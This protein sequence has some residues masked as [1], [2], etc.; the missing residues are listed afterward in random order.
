MSSSI[1]GC[2][3]N[4]SLINQN[5]VE[6][7]IVLFPVPIQQYLSHS[8]NNFGVMKYINS[9][10]NFMASTCIYRTA[11][12]SPLSLSLFFRPGNEARCHFTAKPKNIFWCF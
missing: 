2:D 11:E 6:G 3:L 8:Q 4:Y 1:C 12:T 9:V 5:M 10:K 7:G